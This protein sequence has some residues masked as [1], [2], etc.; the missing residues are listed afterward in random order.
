MYSKDLPKNTGQ[1]PG[2]K[3]FESADGNTL[4][5]KTDD[6]RLVKMA[7]K[8]DI[9]ARPFVILLIA[10]VLGPIIPLV[11]FRSEIVGKLW[12]AIIC[13]MIW[14]VIFVADFIYFVIKHPLSEF[15][16]KIKGD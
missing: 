13:V 9:D 4:Y 5:Y 10:L 16:S 7:D 6:D 12:D 14:L 11:L 8:S 15:Y 3:F 2:N 1:G